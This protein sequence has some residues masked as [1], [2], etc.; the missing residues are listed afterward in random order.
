[1]MSVM[2]QMQMQVKIGVLISSIVVG[3][4]MMFGTFVSAEEMGFSVKTIPSEHQLDKTQTYFDIRV[5][6][7]TTEILEIE[8]QNNTKE[9]VTVLM[10]ANT[11]VTNGNG[12]IDYSNSNP[13][14][15]A[16]MTRDF[17]KMV[18]VDPEVTL[19][20]SETKRVKIPVAIPKESFD[21][22]ILG[23]FHFSQKETDAKKSEQAGVQV[24]NK[25][26][27]VVGV[28]LSENDT[29]LETEVNLLDVMAGQRNYRNTILATLQNP[30][31]HILNNMD[32][33]AYIYNAG[34]TKDAIYYD[35]KE[36]LEM[37]PN[38]SFDYGINMNNNAFKPGKYVMKMT[39]KTKG[40]TFDFTK[41]F[42]IS[43]DESKSL[44][45]EAVE[46]VEAESQWPKYLIGIIVALVM[47][48]TGLVV[49]LLVK[50]KN[51]SQNKSVNKKS[52]KRKRNSK[53]GSKKKKS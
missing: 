19:K 5:T 26:S 51:S 24:K 11:A 36:N 15:D 20:G 16:S 38:S 33:E 29:E 4:M 3:I 17:S 14:I 34:N 8:L 52:N 53:K 21:G 6:P 50:R 12:L 48:I 10:S 23:G 31:A 47:I 45:E 13:K 40:E 1:M 32:V 2:K 30:Q 22:I 27:Y 9:D 39:V 46:L 41:E 35:K 49:Y 7:D 28:R 37:A 44:N 18:D 25:F 43:A 42:S